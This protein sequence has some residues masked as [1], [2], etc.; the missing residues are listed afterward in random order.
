MTGN[1]YV[2]W[3]GIEVWGDSSEDQQLH[4]YSCREIACSAQP[5]LEPHKTAHIFY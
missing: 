4:I 5:L 1:G 3:Q 2:F